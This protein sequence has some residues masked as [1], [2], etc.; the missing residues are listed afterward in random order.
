M[1]KS[2]IKYDPDHP[3]EMKMVW[4]EWLK[5]VKLDDWPDT[6]INKIYDRWVVGK[7]RLYIPQAEWSRI[8]A[9]YL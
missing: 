6:H 8:V 7:V 4:D 1:P 3:H 5:I 2:L 9:T